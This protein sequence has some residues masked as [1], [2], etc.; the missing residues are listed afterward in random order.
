[1]NRQQLEEAQLYLKTK[2]AHVI[3]KMTVDMLIARPQNVAEFMVKWIDEKGDQFEPGNAKKEHYGEKRPLGVESSDEEEDEIVDELPSIAKRLESNVGRR[4]VSAEVYSAGTKTFKPPIVPKTSE[5]KMRIRELLNKIFIFSQL[6]PKDMDVILNAMDFRHFKR[7]ETVINQGDD[8]KE[9]YIVQSGKLN[10]SKVSA[11]GQTLQLKVYYPGEFFGELALL[12]NTPRAATIAALE[13]VELLSLDRE[14]F[15][16]IVRDSMISNTNKFDKFLQEVQVLQG[17]SEYERSKLSDCLIVKN[18]SAG[19]YVIKE[20]EADDIFYLVIEGRATA[21]K[22]N[23]H[24]NQQEEVY[25]YQENTYFGELALIKDEPRAATVMA[26][27]ALKVA[28]IDRNS[29][30]RILGS[31]EDIMKRNAEMYVRF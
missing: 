31:L 18:Y 26:K 4:S 14:T 22:L 10:C 19:E 5:V 11:T 9:L 23:H 29:F 27:T 3:E 6:D 21:F 17:L 30:K 28:C 1:M 8:G 24:T 7:G 2:V 13:N 16:H 20:G 25:Q 12:Y 15:N